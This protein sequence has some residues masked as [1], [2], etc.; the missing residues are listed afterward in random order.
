MFFG[1]VQFWN[2]R[3]KFIPDFFKLKGEKLNTAVVKFIIQ[4]YR[5]SLQ[6]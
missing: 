3:N 6:G 1:K 4:F 2:Y 5:A